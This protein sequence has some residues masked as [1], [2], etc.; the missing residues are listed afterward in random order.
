MRAPVLLVYQTKK[1][2]SSETVLMYFYHRFC[3]T[4]S[5]K[6]SAC[7]FGTIFRGEQK[8]K[9]FEMFESKI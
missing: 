8:K 3:K 7:N 6:V 5:Q 2:L 9:L 4:I 1:G